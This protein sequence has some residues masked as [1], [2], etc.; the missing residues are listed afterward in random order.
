MAFRD[1][2]EHTGNKPKQEWFPLSSDP[3]SLAS[4][5]ENPQGFT[6][7]EPHSCSIR[8]APPSKVRETVGK[9]G[10]CLFASYFATINWPFSHAYLCRSWFRS[11]VQHLKYTAFAA[12]PAQKHELSS[13]WA[14]RILLESLETPLWLP[15]I[16]TIL[17][18]Q[19]SLSINIRDL[20]DL[21]LTWICCLWSWKAG[22]IVQRQKKPW[23]LSCRQADM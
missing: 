18:P 16:L 13:L 22:C 9:P 7:H 5:P 12:L 21:V 17:Y 11:A 23:A 20:H 14:G 6:C 2:K 19:Q 15:S 4:A 1:F 10:N 3:S 8:P